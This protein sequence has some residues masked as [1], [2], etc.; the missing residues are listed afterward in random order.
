MNLSFPR[1]PLLVWILIPT[2]VIIGLGVWFFSKGSGT[3]NESKLDS[4]RPEAVSASVEGTVDYDIVGRNHMAQGTS[5][6]GY[7]SNPPSSG[8]HWP[9]AVK[10]GVYADSLPDE[11]LIHNLEHGHIWI[12]YK[13]DVS[14]DVKS[15][16]SEIVGEE[17]W[18]VVMAPRDQ[19]DTAIAIVAWGRVLK[20]DE[21]DYDKIRSFIRTYRNR[22]P[23]RTPE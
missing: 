1:V 19:N 8:P 11:Q 13:S 4:N 18:K 2:V 6:S 9:A 7:N 15:K 21:P 22:G 12:A 16:L 5:G 14:D 10:N 3:V 17:D 20:M 23:E